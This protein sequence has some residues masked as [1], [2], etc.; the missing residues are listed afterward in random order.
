MDDRVGVVIDGVRWMSIMAG[1]D[2]G[3]ILRISANRESRAT[4]WGRA[5]VGR[6]ERQ[7]G[8][9]QRSGEQSGNPGQ[10]SGQKS[11]PVARGR[12]VAGGVELINNKIICY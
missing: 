5:A 4:A 12:T 2:V 10:S 7:P 11:S 8:A 9:E 3:G 1:I 6:A